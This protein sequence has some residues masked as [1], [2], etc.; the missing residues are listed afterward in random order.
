MHVAFVRSVKSCGFIPGGEDDLG[1]RF[2][3]PRGG[4]RVE[5]L[6]IGQS[7]WF[8]LIADGHDRTDGI[9]V[10]NLESFAGHVLVESRHLVSVEAERGSFQGNE[11]GSG[12][13]IEESEVVGRVV[14]A[15]LLPGCPKNQDR[16]FGRPS[17]VETDKGGCNLLESV[18]VA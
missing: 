6:S 15:E 10:R 5:K 11:T 7:R 13:K 3:R 12:S 18:G 4:F 2:A 1:Q 8:P 16:R 9:F 17:L 14:M